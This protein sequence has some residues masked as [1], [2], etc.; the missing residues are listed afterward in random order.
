MGV[1]TTVVRNIVN[2]KAWSHIDRATIKPDYVEAARL[3]R[4][5]PGP[6]GP[7]SKRN[8]DRSRNYLRWIRT[9]PC[10][11]CQSNRSEAHHTG[12]HGLSVKGS[13]FLTIPLCPQHHRTGQDSY[14]VL[15]RAAFEKHHGISIERITKELQQLA[16]SEGVNL[17]PA[18]RKPMNR[19]SRVRNWRRA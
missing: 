1:S 3:R 2:G 12:P 15:G 4:L 18:P 19:V 16:R 6:F 14:H 10:S 13:D 11:I 5:Y 17:D 7:K 9:Q 8:P